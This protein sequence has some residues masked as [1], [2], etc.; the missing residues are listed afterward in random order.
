ME[1]APWHGLDNEC[2]GSVMV[3][4]MHEASRDAKEFVDQFGSHFPC[5]GAF[6]SLFLSMALGIF[7]LREARWEPSGGTRTHL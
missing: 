5:L 2:L 7:N 4:L 1:L 6:P 3:C